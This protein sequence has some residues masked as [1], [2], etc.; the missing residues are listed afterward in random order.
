[1]QQRHRAS[2]QT[3]PAVVVGMPGAAT[4]IKGAELISGGGA[5]VLGVGMTLKYRLEAGGRK[6]PG[7]VR[8]L[9]WV[10]WAALLVTLG[11]VSYLLL[12]PTWS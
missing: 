9:F 12:A 1:M 3:G 10:C 5:V 6:T 7:W 8:A 2:F 4:L 11:W